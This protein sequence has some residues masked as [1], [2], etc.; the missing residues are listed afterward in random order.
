M[1]SIKARLMVDMDSI[2][3]RMIMAAV[4]VRMIVDTTG[5]E[6]QAGDKDCPTSLEHLGTRV[7]QHLWTCLYSTSTM[8]LLKKP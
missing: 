8:M 1:D 3:F 7:L 2:E 4:M 5:E 6:D